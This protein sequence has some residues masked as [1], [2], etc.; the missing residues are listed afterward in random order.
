ML[1]VRPLMDMPYKKKLGAAFG[2]LVIAAF[3]FILGTEIMYKSLDT[4]PLPNTPIQ[5]AP[6]RLVTDD[7]WDSK[8]L[9]TF[10]SV[11]EWENWIDS[12]DE[13]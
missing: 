4:K 7:P 10:H 6:L 1:A 3:A 8:E 5:R 12:G 11:V 2:A 13:L 9:K